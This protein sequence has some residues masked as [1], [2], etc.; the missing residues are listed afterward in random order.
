MKTGWRNQYYIN[1][2]SDGIT[3][4]GK[5]LL[6]LIVICLLLSVALAGCRKGPSEAGD[7]QSAVIVEIDGTPER[8]AAFERFVKARLSDFAVSQVGVDQQRSSLLDEFIERQVIVRQALSR[9]IEPTDDEIRRTL[10]AQYKQTSSEGASQNQTTLTSAER[11]IEI[12]NDLLA[13]KLYQKE[14]LRDIR[15]SPEEV[16]AHYAAHRDEYERKNGFYVREI[17]VFEEADA[18]RLQ[19][20]VLARPDDFAVLAKEHSDAP[21]AASGGLIYYEADQLPPPLEQAITP[22]KVGSVSRVVKSSFGYHIFKLEQRAEPLPLEKVR[23]EIEARLLSEKEQS[24]IDEFSQRA[25]STARIIIHGDRLGF[26]YRGRFP[27]S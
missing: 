1:D 15:V 5:R 16:E 18:V 8:A 22:L 3:A 17:R 23:Q 20:Q 14:A 12:V 4:R 24:L 19:R 2:I 26:S 6:G 13:L 27:T 11:R 10:E 9:N 21:T 7:D 25:V